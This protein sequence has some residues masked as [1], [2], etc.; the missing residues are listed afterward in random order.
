MQDWRTEPRQWDVAS[1]ELSA[2]S[3]LDH[4]PS[5]QLLAEWALVNVSPGVA[6]AVDAH[7]GRCARCRLQAASSSN[8]S[9]DLQPAVHRQ[10]PPDLGADD[11]VPLP[12]LRVED[13]AQ[14]AEGLEMAVAAQANGLGECVFLLRAVPNAKVSRPALASSFVLL[15]LDGAVY[16]DGRRLG[17]GDFLELQG[18]PAVACADSVAGATLLVVADEAP[19]R[20]RRRR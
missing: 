16:V 4:H 1:A 3:N 17:A 15:V 6:M 14:L 13:W 12:N 5:S 18:A 19:R 11:R 20:P 10:S 7:V 8:R 2:R 9:G